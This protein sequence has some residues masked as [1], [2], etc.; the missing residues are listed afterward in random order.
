MS[1]A[2]DAVTDAVAAPAA[3]AL[4]L[5]GFD[6]LEWWVGNARAF[7]GFLAT[8]FGFEVVAYAGPETGRSDRISYV[9]VQDDIRW[10]VTN[11]LS[12]SSPIAVQVSAHG[13]GVHDIAFRVRDAAFA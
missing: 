12:P 10:V 8:A 5:Q 7:A 9:L 6:H 2:T 1:T 3:Q 4:G 11:G 13:D